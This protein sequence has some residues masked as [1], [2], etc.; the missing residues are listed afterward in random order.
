MITHYVKG[1]SEPLT[2]NFSSHEM[3]CPCHGE[4]CTLTLVDS[5]AVRGLQLLRTYLGQPV[6]ILKGGGFRC[7]DY[8]KDLEERGYP[9]AKKRSMHL[10]GKAF[11]IYCPGL[12]TEKLIEA[13]EHVGFKAIGVAEGWIH[14]DARKDKIRRWNY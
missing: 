2:E 12:S 8:Q 4:E 14:L 10:F 3:D 1:I 9:T 6:R 11:D 5:E 7:G 13:A